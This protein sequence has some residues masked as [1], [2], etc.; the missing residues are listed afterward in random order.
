MSSIHCSQRP[1][2]I[3]RPFARGGYGQSGRKRCEREQY[4]KTDQIVRAEAS[5]L[6][7]RVTFRVGYVRGGH[8]PNPV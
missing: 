5:R 4:G 6:V 2:F 8:G 7:Y 1:V 3:A